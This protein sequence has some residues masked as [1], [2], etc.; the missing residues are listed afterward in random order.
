ME[1]ELIE[2][3]KKKQVEQQHALQELQEA[4]SH[5][6]RCSHPIFIDYIH[7]L[8]SYS[9]SIICSIVFAP[10]C[11]CT[12]SPW[13]A[14]N[15]GTIHAFIRCGPGLHVSTLGVAA[16]TLCTTLLHMHNL[17]RKFLSWCEADTCM[18]WHICIVTMRHLHVVNADE[19]SALGPPRLMFCLHPCMRN[20]DSQ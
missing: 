6:S 1:L 7:Y 17:T 5:T 9:I 2:R 18:L 15:M 4:M 19:S 16:V 13:R 20:P 10:A 12:H 11:F 8:L 3:L 14:V